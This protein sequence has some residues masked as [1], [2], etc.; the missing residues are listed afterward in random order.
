MSI[1]ALCS[2]PVP[3]EESEGKKKKSLRRESMR[4]KFADLSN[5]RCNGNSGRSIQFTKQQLQHQENAYERH[6][7]TICQY[8]FHSVVFGHAHYYCFEQFAFQ[9]TSVKGQCESPGTLFVSLSSLSAICLM[10]KVSEQQHGPCIF[11]RC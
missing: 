9:R 11:I 2:R 8:S 4:V 10:L 1:S 6:P 7:L 3:T 5:G